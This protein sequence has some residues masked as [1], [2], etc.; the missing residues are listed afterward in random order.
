MLALLQVFLSGFCGAL[1]AL[2]WAVILEKIIDC[3]AERVCG[4]ATLEQMDGSD[5]IT[6]LLACECGPD[7]MAFGLFVELHDLIAITLSHCLGARFEIF[8]DTLTI[9]RSG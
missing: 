6:V 3:K 1:L 7:R 8:T 4:L 5:G 2:R 9:E